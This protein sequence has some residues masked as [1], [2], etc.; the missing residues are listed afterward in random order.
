MFSPICL[1]VCLSAI[2]QK[3]MDGFRQNYGQ[4]GSVTRTN[5]FDFADYPDRDTII[6]LIPQVI[7][8]HGEMGQKN[9]INNTMPF[10][11]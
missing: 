4:V 1:P 10:I 8:H 9:D 5:Q 6:F 11:P 7:L 3:V 2:S